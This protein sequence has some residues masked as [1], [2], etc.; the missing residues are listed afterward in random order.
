MFEKPEVKAE[1]LKKISEVAPKKAI[2]GSNT[3]SISITYLSKFVSNPERFLG[4]HFFNPVPVMKL[5]E[6]VKGDRTQESVV[7]KVFEMVKALGG[8]EPVIS[9]DFPGFIA[10]R[11]LVPLIREPYC[12][13]RRA[14]Q[15][16]TT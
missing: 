16:R 3:S 13:W 4:I 5:V 11:V 14:W 6:V 8:K 12:S 1:T 2:I 7:R 10:N 9:Q 15:P